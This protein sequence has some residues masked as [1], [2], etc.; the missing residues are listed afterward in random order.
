MRFHYKKTHPSLHEKNRFFS[1]CVQISLKSSFILICN[2]S[3]I[4]AQ[5]NKATDKAISGKKLTGFISNEWGTTFSTLRKELK[6]LST[7]ENTDEKVEILNIVRNKLVLVRRSDI[8]YRYSF[9]KTPYAVRRL[10][11][12]ELKESEYDEKVEGE[13]FCVQV[14]I[15]VIETELVREKL[16]KKYGKSQASSKDD[17]GFGVDIWELDGGTIFLWYESQGKKSFSRR[18]DYLSSK[19][20]QKITKEQIHYFDANQKLLLRK[21]KL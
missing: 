14:Q 17:T 12:E 9:Y 15:P 10:E 18:I 8:I 3:P 19:H 13:L 6:N 20:S 5:E 21:S 2:F 11:V 7:A 4:V 16:T 1:F